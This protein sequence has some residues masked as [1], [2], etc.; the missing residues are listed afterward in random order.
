MKIHI[1]S[2]PEPILQHGLSQFSLCGQTVLNAVPVFMFDQLCIAW[3]LTDVPAWRDCCRKCL[4]IEAAGRYLYGICSG[5]ELIERGRE[6]EL[7][8]TA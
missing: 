3:D 1:I 5:Q 8:E 6:E 2:L 7:L 4:R